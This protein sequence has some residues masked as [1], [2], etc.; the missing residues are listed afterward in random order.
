MANNQ[1]ARYN[2][3]E[4]LAFTG[5]S[6]LEDGKSVFVGTGLPMIAGM[7]AQKTHA[8]HLLIIFEAGG[9]GPILPELPISVGQALTCHR[10][11]AATSMHDV[12]SCCQ[13][14]FVDYGFLGGAQVD[15]YGNI[16]TTCIG[17]HDMPKARLPG[18][19]GANDI[20]S[21]AHKTIIIVGG[22]SKRTFVNKVDF[23]TTPGYLSGPG[24]REKAG[25]PSG[26]G[27]FR[28]ITQL[29]VYGFDEKT[30]GMKLI[31]LHPGVSVEE[32]RD[33]SSFD[34]IIPDKYT[35]SPEPSDRDLEILR[36]DIDPTGMLIGK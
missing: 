17:D 12:M 34:I 21:F 16:N 33:N 20:A 15:M 4:F 27:P 5:A 24:A 11:I 31:S 7:L 26:T 1:N 30:K 9:V 8:P 18:S 28:M 29:A 19:G 25:L 13:A 32:V 14:G 35:V 2:M 10:G 23:L 22:Q 3:R 6:M 36:K